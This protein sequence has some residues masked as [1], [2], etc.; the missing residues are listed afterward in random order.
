MKRLFL[1][2]LLVILLAFSYLI[3]KKLLEN[4][5]L[6]QYGEKGK[7]VIF[8]IKAGTGLKSTAKLLKRENVIK[9]EFLFLAGHSIFFTRKMVK[10]GEYKF[11]FPVSIYEVLKKITKGEIYLHSIT[12]PEG[13]SI[14]DIA[15]ILEGEGIV[16]GEDFKKACEKKEFLTEFTTKATNLEG[17]LFPDTYF[18]PKG[19]N[20]EK[21]VRIMLERFK[22]KVGSYMELAKKKG[23]D[24]YE[25]DIIASIIE[26]ETGVPS[27]RP[28]V[29]SVIHNRLR[30]GMPLQ[31]DPTVIYALKKK[32]LYTPPLKPE[33]LSFPSPYNTYI[34][35]GLPPGPICNPG[36][37]SIESALNPAKTDYL[38]FVSNGDGTHTFSSDL[39]SHNRAVMNYKRK[40]R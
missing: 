5:I 2:F 16:K 32:S 39:S 31:C 29:S 8:E 12:I 26:K 4:Q 21:I 30:I 35:K 40:L 36:L 28:L 27:E 19:I 33:F 3:G 25:L 37:E 6:M 10:A 18:F 13:S 34:H 23:I 14:D 38:Y 20:P 9:S 22:V 24:F 1:F 17:F 11:E 15:E 7:F